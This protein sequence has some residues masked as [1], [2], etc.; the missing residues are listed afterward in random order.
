[1]N[2]LEKMRLQMAGDRSSLKQ[3]KIATS[4]RYISDTF[5]DDPTYQEDGVQIVDGEIIYPRIWNYKKS[6]NLSPTVEIQ[7]RIQEEFKRGQLLILNGEYW[8]CLKSQCYHGMYWTGKLKQCTHLLQY[9]DAKTHEIE[10]SWA[11]LERPYSRTLNNGDIIT[12]SEMEF[13]A[14]LPFNDSTK[15]INL[16]R[17]LLTGIEY[18]EYGNEIGSVYKITGRDGSSQ[19][20]NG[21]GFLVLNMI[22]DQF[23]KDKDNLGLMIAD[24]ID[25]GTP[26]GPPEPPVGGLLMCEIVGRNDIRI[27]GS[28]RSF[29]AKF[30]DV[31]GV[32][33]AQVGVSP[34]WELIAPAGHEAYYKISLSD[35][36][37]VAR[38]TAQANNELIDDVLVLRLFDQEGRYA[39]VEM[40]VTVVI[41]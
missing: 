7:T 17:R 11:V 1:M 5:Q 9:Q 29:A 16:D 6:D 30:Y 38:V 33:E 19:V 31:D 28:P 18:D 12:T 37:F 32:T 13:K 3:D 2:G 34:I 21:E 26:P 15:K 41:I 23:N 10:S 24:Y 36:N 25:P 40:S 27:G 35:D 14:M 8:L 20:I 22:Q 39:N 4:I